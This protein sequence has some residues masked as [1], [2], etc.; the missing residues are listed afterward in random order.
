MWR[1][2]FFF[3]DGSFLGKRLG[4]LLSVEGYLILLPRRPFARIWDDGIGTLNLRVKAVSEVSWALVLLFSGPL[5]LAGCFVEK[6][7]F[8]GCVFLFPWEGN[9]TLCFAHF[10]ARFSSFMRG[11]PLFSYAWFFSLLND[12]QNE[13]RKKTKKKKNTPPPLKK[14]DK[15]PKK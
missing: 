9:R 8:L 1:F 5:F 14:N 4:D 11:F 3:F 12:L 13:A 2:S 10:D 15:T 6:V 7:V